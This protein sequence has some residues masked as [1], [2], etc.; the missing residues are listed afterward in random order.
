MT[1]KTSKKDI[2]KAVRHVQE[3]ISEYDYNQASNSELNSCGDDKFARS[4]LEKYGF[5][6]DRIVLLNHWLDNVY[7][8]RDGKRFLCGIICLAS[9]KDSPAP[10][11]MNIE[12]YLRQIL[13]GACEFDAC[14]FLSMVQI[15]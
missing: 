15:S 6:N 13:I 1:L 7:I 4:I 14:I 10:I 2:D 9:R 5:E 12:L 3:L 8:S 11:L